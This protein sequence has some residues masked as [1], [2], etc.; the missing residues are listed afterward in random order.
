MATV[1]GDSPNVVPILPE[2]AKPTPADFLQAAAIVHERQKNVRLAPRSD[3]SSKE[4][5]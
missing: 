2:W 1:P 5:I 3:N 4:D